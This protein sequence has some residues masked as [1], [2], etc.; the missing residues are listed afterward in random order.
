[1]DEKSIELYQEEQRKLL[2]DLNQS[3]REVKSLIDIQV[4]QYEAPVK[5]VDVKGKVTVNTEKNVSV[6]N[7]SDVVEA[8]NE[9]S[10]IITKSLKENSYKP[11]ESVSVKNIKDAKP[12]SIKVNNLSELSDF[13]KGLSKDI[14]DN[15][16]I[17]NVTKQDVVFPTSPLNP[18]SVRLSDGKSFYNAI[19]AAVSSGT[20]MFRDQA[21]R[22]AV[23]ELTADGKVPVEAG[24]TSVYESRNDTTTDANLV[25]LAKALPGSATTDAVW[26][27]KRYN[28]SA[29]TMT[30]ADDVT[31]FTKVWND[32][33]GY[34]Y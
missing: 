34:T 3:I 5:E 15:K 12:D 4:K 19:A 17:V 11:L 14:I 23:V 21:G 32:R 7:I 8:L 2:I 31:N 6:D 22:S 26:Q 18:I 30:F 13:F 16:P 25:Y 29:G 33:T 10:G 20:A 27:I 9:L 1:M 24:S 28:K